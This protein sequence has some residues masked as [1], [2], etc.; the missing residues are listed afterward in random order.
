M[1]LR[2][3]LH[4]RG[5]DAAIS[6]AWYYGILLVLSVGLY[7]LFRYLITRYGTG[8]VQVSITG[9]AGITAVFLFIV[10][11]NSYKTELLFG[12]Q[13]GISR[14]TLFVSVLLVGLA[15]GLFTGVLDLLQDRLA[16]GLFGSLGIAITGIEDHLMPASPFPILSQYLGIVALNTSAFFLGVL[17]SSLFYRLNTLGKVLVPIGAVLLSMLLSLTNVS[18]ESSPGFLPEL[19]NRIEAFAQ[20]GIFPFLLVHVAW[21]ALLFLLIWLLQRRAQVKTQLS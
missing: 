20:S 10:G 7:F 16:R 13:N 18:T 17:I 21:M 1:N 15:L 8:V 4:Y 5:K 9:M 3:I 12:L 14:R 2:P 6:L 19:S 11:L